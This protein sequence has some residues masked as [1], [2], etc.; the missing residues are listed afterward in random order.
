MEEQISI[1]A[2]I[3]NVITKLES[4]LVFIA[5]VFLMTMLFTICIAVGSRAILGVSI[6]W[7]NELASYLML[8]TVF[9]VAP[10]V[11]KHNDHVVVDIFTYNLSGKW[12]KV[13]KLFISFIGG[14]ACTFYFWFSFIITI[15]HFNA[16]TIDV[17]SFPWP[18]YVL[19]T[20]MVVGFFFLIIRFL[21]IFITILKN[22]ENNADK[23]TDNA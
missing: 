21:M 14:I 15:H 16:G 13:N 17:G 23:K 8:G 3:D 6:L 7:T 18:R 11:L 19:Y 22:I 2:R 20:P 10:W 5:G 9:L 12:L 1:Y 4:V